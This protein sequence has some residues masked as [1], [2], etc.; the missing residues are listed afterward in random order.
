MI[1]IILS[2][3]FAIV[4]VNCTNATATHSEIKQVSVQ[5]ANE[6]LMKGG[7]QF[8]DVRTSEEFQPEHPKGAINIPM[9]TVEKRISEFATDKPIYLICRSGRRSQ[10]VAEMLEKK[11]FKNLVNVTG[12]MLEWSAAGLPTAK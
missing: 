12:G 11:G 5:E 6:A 7:I 4:S 8:V 1:L 9:E 10:I 3:I 2:L